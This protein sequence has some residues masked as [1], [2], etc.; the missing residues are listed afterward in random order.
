MLEN[1]AQDPADRARLIAVSSEHAGD[2]LNALPIT[3]CGLRLDDETVRIG[4]GL[5]LGLNLCEPHRCHC[6][7]QVDNRGLHCL[8]CKVGPGRL[9]R[10]NLLNDIL[11][12]AFISAGIPA[13]KEPRRLNRADQRRPDGMTLVPW[14]DGK[15]LTW[16]VTVADTQAQS[17][18]HM[19]VHTPGAVAEAAAERKM[20][21]YEC[22]T[23]HYHFVPVAFETLGPICSAGLDLIN[24]LG[25]KISNQTQEPRERMF[26]FQRL[27]IALQRGNAAIFH[28]SFDVPEQHTVSMG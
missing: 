13:L 17:Y 19:S 11:C 24:S 5:R 7:I 23:Q 4:V 25:S 2:W 6:G 22:I 10:H 9:I 12:R 3:S 15:S 21:K 27:S 26:L 14:S 28:S 20:K 8:S 1:S 16:D 18:I